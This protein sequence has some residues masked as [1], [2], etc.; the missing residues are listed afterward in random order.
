MFKVLSE[1]KLGRNPEASVFLLKEGDSV[2]QTAKTKS[3]LRSTSNYRSLLRRQFGASNKR[4]RILEAPAHF[5]K[6]LSLTV[7]SRIWTSSYTLNGSARAVNPASTLRGSGEETQVPGA[8]TNASKSKERSL[9]MSTPCLVLF[10][11]EPAKKDEQEL[12]SICRT[13]HGNEIKH[14]TE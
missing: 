10:D 7:G 14:E 11:Y 9:P 8:P 1:P 5:S 4:Q 13:R 12:C 6:P 3:E 2:C